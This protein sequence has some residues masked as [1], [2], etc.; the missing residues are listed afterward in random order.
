MLYWFADVDRAVMPVASGVL[1]IDPFR[2]P[3]AFKHRHDWNLTR[4]LQVLD[5][6]LMQIKLIYAIG[7]GA[8]HIPKL[9]DSLKIVQFYTRSGAMLKQIFTPQPG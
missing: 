3:F 5:S 1:L 7:S 6:G 4:I 2:G 8:N 9:S